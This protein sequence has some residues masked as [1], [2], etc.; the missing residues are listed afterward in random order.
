[1]S[2][3]KWNSIGIASLLLF[4]AC[5]DDQPTPR[6]PTSV[7]PA[8]VADMATAPAPAPS[9]PPTPTPT[10]PTATSAAV[11]VMDNFFTPANVTIGAGGTVT[12]TLAGAHSHTATSNTAA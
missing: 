5:G 10:P 8:P 12:W 7:P 3:T 1:M 2:N 4:T 9:T 11:T 6:T